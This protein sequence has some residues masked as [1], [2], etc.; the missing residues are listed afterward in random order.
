M[1]THGTKFAVPFILEYELVDLMI[2]QM[3]QLA[4]HA[5]IN[6]SAHRVSHV[7]LYI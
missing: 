1:T 2:W 5:F 3:E 7:H 4:S 6:K